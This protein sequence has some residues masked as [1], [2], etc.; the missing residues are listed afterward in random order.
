MTLETT[1]EPVPSVTSDSSTLAP[2][3]S[4]VPSESAQSPPPPLGIPISGRHLHSSDPIWIDWIQ[5]LQKTGYSFFKVDV[6]FNSSNA[7]EMESYWLHYFD[8]KIVYKVRKVIGPS[9]NLIDV[10]REYEFG[11]KFKSRRSKDWRCPHHIHAILGVPDDR[12]KQM[13]STGMARDLNSLAEVSSTHI[14]LIPVDCSD[15]HKTVAAAFAY[16]R[17]GKTHRPLV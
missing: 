14:E 13:L 17:K 8:Q 5:N 12:S 3:I 1:I 2:S 6:T 9:H 10:L 16:M 7:N 4:P 11:S 15:P